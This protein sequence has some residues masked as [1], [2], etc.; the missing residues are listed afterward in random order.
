ML[1][2]ID[3]NFVEVVQENCYQGI[4]TIC[5]NSKKFLVQLNSST[6]G[7]PVRLVG[8]EHRWALH[9]PENQA[10]DFLKHYWVKGFE[11]VDRLT[12]PARAFAYDYVLESSLEGDGPIHGDYGFCWPEDVEST[13]TGLYEREDPAADVVSFVPIWFL[14]DELIGAG[15]SAK[16]SQTWIEEEIEGESNG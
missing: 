1:F 5:T 10:P 15:R 11:K 9:V 2:F 8:S 3:G 13:K 12:G 14:P 4:I 16:L 6:L 7:E